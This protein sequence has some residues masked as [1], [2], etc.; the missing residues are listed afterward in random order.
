MNGYK[1]MITN[2]IIV[3]YSMKCLHF[4]ISVRIMY[5]FKKNKKLIHLCS[6]RADASDL[7]ILH[8]P[9]GKRCFDFNY[10]KAFPLL[11]SSIQTGRVLHSNEQRN[12]CGDML[13]NM[14]S[15]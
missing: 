8:P 10:T 14:R 5:I 3:V 15:M 12:F 11:P 4:I 9:I 13:S 1:D 6:C 7:N 2:V